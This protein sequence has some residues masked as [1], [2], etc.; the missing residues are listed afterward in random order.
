MQVAAATPL[1]PHNGT[2][3]KGAKRAEDDIS[4]LG[5]FLFSPSNE[6]RV[7]R[8]CVSPSGEFMIFTEKRTDE[9]LPNF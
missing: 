8:C 5:P 3:R 6:F 1:K 9:E 7:I 4:F 2:F